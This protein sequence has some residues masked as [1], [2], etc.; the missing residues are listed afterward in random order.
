MDWFSMFFHQLI[1]KKILYEQ[2]QTLPPRLH[3]VATQP[4]ESWKPKNVT[5]FDSILYKL[6]TCSWGHFEDLI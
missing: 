1:R 6:L 3:Y 4:C 5:N 2:A